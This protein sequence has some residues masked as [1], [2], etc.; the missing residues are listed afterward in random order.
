MVSR[1]WLTILVVSLVVP[2]LTLAVVL[3]YALP[4]GN[5]SGKPSPS[6]SSDVTKSRP[7]PWGDLEYVRIIIEPP[8]EFVEDYPRLAGNKWHFA[9]MTRDQLQTFLSADGL[10]AAQRDELLAAAAAMP[11]I[12]GFVIDR[13]DTTAQALTPE[14]RA[15][16]YNLLGTDGLNE[17]QSSAY[18]FVADTPD[19]WLEGLSLAPE[20]LSLVK[21]LIY[22]HGRYLLFADFRIILP[23]LSAPQE[24]TRFLKVLSRETT[25]LVYL[26]VTAESDIDS[27]VNY[28]GRGGRAKDIRPILDSLAQARGGGKIDITHLL[29]G[30]ARRRIYTFPAPGD[31]N[32]DTGRHCFWTAL[33]FFS[34]Q[35]DERFRDKDVILVTIKQQYDEIYNNLLMGDLVLFL[36]GDDNVIHAAVY[37]ADDILYTKN[38]N[39]STSP[40]MF[41]RMDEMKDYYP[42]AKPQVVRYFRRK[43]L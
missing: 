40:W 10:T 6:Y 35:P 43:D 17:A 18:R 20:K 23:M 31:T 32:P 41:I 39:R 16:L 36:D 4:K 26:R 38:G 12:K 11:E 7:G 33:N 3:F 29:P 34:E 14:A 1:R 42:T 28:W 5:G 24:R 13:K 25:M 21:S 9:N 15:H 30:F 22:R 2:W 8:T 27:L 37:I 19:E